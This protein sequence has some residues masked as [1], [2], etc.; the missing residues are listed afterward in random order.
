[1]KLEIS[2]K[3][4]ESFVGNVCPL[5]LGFDSEM[6][7]VLRTAD[8]KWSTDS[9]VV[10]IRGFSGEL[11]TNFNHGVLLSLV[12]PGNATVSAIYN[13]NVYT[14]EVLV[15]ERLTVDDS[16]PL[17]HYIGDMHNH[18]TPIHNS[19]DYLESKEES[20]KLFVENVA[21][22]DIIDVCAL[23]D[24]AGVINDS[25]FFRGFVETE[26]MENTGKSSVV[27]LSGAE[28]EVG[29]VEY[30]RFNIKRRS[31]GEIVTVNS[32][33]YIDTKSWDEFPKAIGISPDPICIFAHPTTTGI[34][35]NGVWNFDFK[36]RNNPEMLRIFRGVELGSGNYAHGVL[37]YEYAYSDALD[38]GFKVAPTGSSDKHVPNWGKT[39]CFAKTVVMA[40]EKSREAFVDA[41]RNNR[42]YATETGKV[43]LT[44]SVNGKR[45]PATL[46]EA[47]NYKFHVEVSLF[48]DGTP[49]DMPEILQVVSDYGMT[50]KEIEGDLSGVDF[51]IE[52]DT[53]RY[54]Y[55]RLLDK[56]R[57]RT[58]SCPV[59]TGREYDK[60]NEKVYTDVDMSDFT[61]LDLDSGA[62][63]TIVLKDTPAECY[64]SD[65]GH[66]TLLIDMKKET[67]LCGFKFWQRYVNRI[68]RSIDPTWSEETYNTTFAT[69]YIVSLSNDGENFTKVAEGVFRAF[70]G[71][72]TVDFGATTARYMRID[73]PRSTGIRSMLERYKDSKIAVGNIVIVK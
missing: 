3:K 35:T 27:I 52:S 41:F 24:H 55:L 63:A 53:A 32:A 60:R 73:L 7:D 62:D 49:K 71:E 9:D 17:N 42:F 1:M 39:A 56:N 30:D 18:T 38:V 58:W 10:E 19:K 59:F 4:I 37:T 11:V 51:E 15:H 40:P 70:G 16:T 54:F 26:K 13:G 33:G 23:S 44:Y 6:H 21:G 61:V 47:T 67:E 5:H 20:Q 12:K 43:K 2:K 50:V 48:E 8:I 66:A 46:D 68:P 65:L 22:E 29:Y 69:D 14:C 34:S 31:S 57:K 72:E 36:N 45:A 25:A 28:S 64:E